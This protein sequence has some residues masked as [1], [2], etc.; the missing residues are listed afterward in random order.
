MSV[1]VEGSAR[2][3]TT[4]WMLGGSLSSQAGGR[5]IGEQKEV[6]EANL[7]QNRDFPIL[8]EYRS[9]LGGLFGRMYGLS[10]AQMQ[11]VFPQAQ[12]RDL[13]LV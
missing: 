10:S 11:Q 4:Y 8:N 9:V 2:H 6:T 7:F 13:K 12:M 3:G 1:G 5:V